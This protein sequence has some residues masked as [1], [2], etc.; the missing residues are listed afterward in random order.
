MR[1]ALQVRNM[2]LSVNNWQMERPWGPADVE[3]AIVI[4]FDKVHRG[5]VSVEER[6]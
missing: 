6:T 1:G 2:L 5:I 3:D 4:D